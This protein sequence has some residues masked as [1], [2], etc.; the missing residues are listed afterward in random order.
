MFLFQAM[1]NMKCSV[2]NSLPLEPILTLTAYV[3]KTVLTGRL[4][5]ASRCSDSEEIARTL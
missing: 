5:L 2:H 3:F 4:A 1:L